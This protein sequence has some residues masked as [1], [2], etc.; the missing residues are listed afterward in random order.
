MFLMDSISH[1]QESDGT[2]DASV[3]ANPMQ[4]TIDKEI[5]KSVIS[6]RKLLANIKTS[7]PQ[8]DSSFLSRNSFFRHPSYYKRDTD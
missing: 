7:A 1:I 2:E 8:K 4:T 3:E 5:E 6:Q